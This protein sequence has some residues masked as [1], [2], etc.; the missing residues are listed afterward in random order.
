[1][2]IYEYQCAKCGEIREELRSIAESDLP[3][4]GPCVDRPLHPI[5]VAAGVTRETKGTQCEFKR[6]LSA[7]PTTFRFNDFTG[8][9]G[10]D[11]TRGNHGPVKRKVDKV[12]K[13]W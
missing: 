3:L 5:E 1:M 4:T 11:R 9:G 10:L 13:Q 6:I 2:P 12:A 7:T 8:Y